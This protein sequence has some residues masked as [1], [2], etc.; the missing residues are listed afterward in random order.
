MN[1]WW[2]LVKLPLIF[3]NVKI[4]LKYSMFQVHEAL[5]PPVPR[6]TGD[7]PLQSCLV[8]R[9]RHQ[10]QGSEVLQV[11]EHYCIHCT[12]IRNKEAQFFR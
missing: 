11:K 5:Q 12:A 8:D 9:V 6:P 4:L 1:K 10:E 7:P 2:F 3:K